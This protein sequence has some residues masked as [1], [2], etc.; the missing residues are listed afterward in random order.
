MN[1]VQVPFK[2]RDNSVL[3][4][5]VHQGKDISSK[6][7]GTCEH[8]HHVVSLLCKYHVPYMFDLQNCV[9]HTI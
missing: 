4:C 1:L 3:F 6:D 5:I 7:T 9:Y 8:C 2:A